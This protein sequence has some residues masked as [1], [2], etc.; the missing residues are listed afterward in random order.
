MADTEKSKNSSNIPAAVFVEDVD[1]FMKQSGNDSIAVVF[2]RVEEQYS[3]YQ[4]MELNLRAKKSR[5]KDQIPDIKSSL[6]IVQHMQST[7]NL[8]E[9]FQTHFQLGSNVYMKASVPA[10]DRVCLWLGANVML[11]YSLD[12][13][14]ALLSKN[15]EAAIK[16]LAQ[17]DE[18]LSFLREQLT[19]LEVTRARV[20]NWE[21]R[22]Q[23]A[24]GTASAWWFTCLSSSSSIDA[25]VCFLYRLIRFNDI[26]LCLIASLC[27]H[28][29]K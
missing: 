7:K 5:L 8:S 1:E 19:T 13:A 11:E 14:E 29:V 27:L 25:S 22:R 3:K 26:V 9:T 20:Y 12:D 4:F 23:Q 21:V 24:Q 15:H 28:R 18:D 2:Q 6:D 10:T 16:S 17:V